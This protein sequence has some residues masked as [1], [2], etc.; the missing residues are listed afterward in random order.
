MPTAPLVMRGLLAD[1]ALHRVDP[2]QLAIGH[3][4]AAVRL[5]LDADEVVDDG[6]DEEVE[7]DEVTWRYRGDL[8]EM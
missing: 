4:R 7:R 8:G 3:G 5:R 6:A 2:L 1:H